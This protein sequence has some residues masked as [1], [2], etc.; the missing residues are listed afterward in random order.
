MW[1]LL[2]LSLF[3]P[4]M[5]WASAPEV[6]AIL[7]SKVV[8]QYE[9]SR[10][11]LAQGELHNGIKLISIKG[12]RVTLEVAG[13]QGHYLLGERRSISS[14]FSSPEP[15]ALRLYADSLGMYRTKGSVNG[16]PIDFMVDTGA[17]S[18]ALNSR[19]ARRLGIDYRRLGT[20]VMLSTASKREWGYR[21][22]L[23][24]VQVGSLVVY[25]VVAVVLDNK[26]FPEK[27]L[28]GM[29]F[30]N[31]VDMTRSGNSLLL[32]ARW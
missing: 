22:R 2:W 24:K 23:N 6:Q 9:G 7:G 32:E 10:L 29:S 26:R 16:I 14:R 13:E 21:V 4:V 31:K 8:V 19:D 15:K 25:D 18:I 1:K 27:A 17:T 11:T 20:K 12:E 3:L 30:L 5:G 28:L